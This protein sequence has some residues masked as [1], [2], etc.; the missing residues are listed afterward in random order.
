MSKIDF[1]YL[2]APHTVDD[3][4]G[5]YWQQCS[6]LI[7]RG[8]PE[9]FRDLLAAPDLEAVL[10]MA[11]QLPTGAVESGVCLK[12]I[13]TSLIPPTINLVDPDP[14]CALD[15]VPLKARERRVRQV[16]SNS[17]GFGGTNACLIFRAFSD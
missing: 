15:F 13:E 4:F 16:M 8:E 17:F 6:L 10:G 7:Q 1:S 3:F 9:R 5:R 12:A 14:E 11:D 2:I